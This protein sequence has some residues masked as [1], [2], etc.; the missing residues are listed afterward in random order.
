MEIEMHCDIVC[1]EDIY[2]GKFENYQECIDWIADNNAYPDKEDFVITVEYTYN[3]LK[4]LMEK[5][6]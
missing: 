6:I 1:G 3:E 2:I 5:L 4:E